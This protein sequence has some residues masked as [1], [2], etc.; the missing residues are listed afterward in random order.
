MKGKPIFTLI[1]LLVVIAIIAILAAMLLP[2]LN[3]ARSKAQ[4]TG[5]LNNLK[6]VGLSTAMYMNDNNDFMFYWSDKGVYYGVPSAVQ[7][8]W[9][10]VLR[11]NKYLPRDYV[12]LIVCPN[13]LS[14][15]A[16]SSDGADYSYGSIN[17]NESR[18]K[19]AQWQTNFRGL[20]QRKVTRPS[21]YAIIGDSVNLSSGAPIGAMYINQ[22][23][24]LMFSAHHNG[25][26]NLLF[27]G[28]NASSPSP[29]E[30]TENMTSAVVGTQN[31]NIAVKGAKVTLSAVAE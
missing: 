8:R 30:Y 27:A 21:N 3:A 20:S 25:R 1:E 26:G 10:Q 31:I 22:V 9:T 19:G 12:K 6:Q 7:A 11:Y 18:L 15:N 14:N 13:Q 28:G 23:A 16:Y 29:D 17:D 24:N 2:A 4:M 5:C